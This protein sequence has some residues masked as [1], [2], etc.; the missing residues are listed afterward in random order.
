MILFGICLFKRE[1]DLYSI[2]YLYNILY[3]GAALGSF[4]AALNK[5]S[6]DR[7]SCKS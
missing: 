4:L 3:T 2:K 6:V 7:Y 1:S 5:I